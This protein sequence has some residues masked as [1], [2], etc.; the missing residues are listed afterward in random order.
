M[1]LPSPS[2]PH[3]SHSEAISR[4]TLTPTEGEDVSDIEDKRRR[5]RSSSADGIFTW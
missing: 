1:M 3:G 5:R 2:K 4:D